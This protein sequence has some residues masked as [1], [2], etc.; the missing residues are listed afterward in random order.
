MVDCGVLTFAGISGHLLNHSHPV[1]NATALLIDS[2][3]KTN[4]LLWRFHWLS[5]SGLIQFSQYPPAF[6]GLHFPCIDCSCMAELTTSSRN[7]R[8]HSK[9]QLRLKT[10]Q[11]SKSFTN[12]NCYQTYCT[13]QV[14]LSQ[15]CHKMHLQQ[16]AKTE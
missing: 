9:P 7:Q 16:E 10:F 4:F 14:P 2:A 1:L 5:I 12:Y 15:M 6:Q 8:L 11:L 3:S 13:R